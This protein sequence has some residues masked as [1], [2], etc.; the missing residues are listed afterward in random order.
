MMETSTSVTRIS[1]EDVDPLQAKRLVIAHPV[2]DSPS[3]S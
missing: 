2:A 1:M 3:I